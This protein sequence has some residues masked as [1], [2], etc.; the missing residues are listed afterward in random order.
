MLGATSDGLSFKDRLIVSD[1]AFCWDV[2]DVN[3]STTECLM[4][5]LDPS[6]VL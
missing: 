4:N 5:K 1:E 3:N 2:S 6:F